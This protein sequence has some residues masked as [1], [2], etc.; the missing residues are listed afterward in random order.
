MEPLSYLFSDECGAVSQGEVGSVV[1]RRMDDD[2]YLA[3]CKLRSNDGYSR[4]CYGA[5]DTPAI[6][7]GRLE[8]AVRRGSRW[9][10]DKL[11]TR[12]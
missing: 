9:R 6:A 3:I 12:F 2:S 11:E 4:V 8:D 10:V 7:L 5:G 1:I